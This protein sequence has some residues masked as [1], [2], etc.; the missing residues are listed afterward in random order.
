MLQSKRSGQ[1]A[2]LGK[3][4]AALPGT[5]S[6][7]TCFSW[8][9]TELQLLHLGIPQKRQPL[10]SFHS[11]S[12]SWGDFWNLSFLWRLM[13][14]NDMYLDKFHCLLILFGTASRRSALCLLISRILHCFGIN[15][16]SQV[17]VGVTPPPK[18]KHQALVWGIGCGHNFFCHCLVSCMRWEYIHF[19]SRIFPSISII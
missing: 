19:T 17:F 15:K 8:L 9:V 14:Y 12:G 7:L 1:P 3:L 4:T 13:A 16:M 11:C 2:G 6:N 10:H 18:A 5:T